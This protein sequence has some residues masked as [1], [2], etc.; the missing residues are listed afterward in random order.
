MK[1]RRLLVGLTLVLAPMLF[2]RTPARAEAGSL[3]GRTF[4]GEMTEK[5]KAKG[6]QDEI[7]FKDGKF[8]S[9]ACDAYGFV[10]TAYSAAAKDGVTTFDA[11][12]ESPRKGTMKW[13]GTVKGDAIEGTAVWMKTGQAD[14]SYTFKGTLKK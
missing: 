14:M 1:R 10:E 11:T 13:K 6:N 3:D 2:A 9:T 7:V 12:A 5:G 4:V 8:R